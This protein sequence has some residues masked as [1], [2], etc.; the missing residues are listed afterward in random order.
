MSNQDPCQNF[1][2]GCLFGDCETF[3]CPIISRETQVNYSLMQCHTSVFFSFC[4]FH[5][6]LYPLWLLKF[7]VNHIVIQKILLWI[8][9]M[10]LS[11]SILMLESQAGQDEG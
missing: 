1:E 6:H 4:P 3:E 11:I 9:W 10:Y 7:A 8:E 2:T 5:F